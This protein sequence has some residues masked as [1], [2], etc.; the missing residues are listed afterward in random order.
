MA[1][2]ASASFSRM[3]VAGMSSCTS[4]LSNAL[5]CQAL[6]RDKRSLSSLLLIEGPGSLRQTIFAP[7]DRR[8]ANHTLDH[9][10]TGKEAVGCICF[11]GDTH[12][13]R[14]RLTVA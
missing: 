9:G 5:G 2:K 4:A 3:T 6:M 14:N 13:F 8:P 11:V 1:K 7:S 12:S 10:R